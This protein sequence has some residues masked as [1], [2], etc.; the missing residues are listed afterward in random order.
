MMDAGVRAVGRCVV[1]KRVCLSMLGETEFVSWIGGL[2]DCDEMCACVLDKVL[3]D[4][5]IVGL[6]YAIK[7]YDYPSMPPPIIRN[8]EM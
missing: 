4:S 7:V 8:A 5:G 6:Y 3:L 2:T 1:V